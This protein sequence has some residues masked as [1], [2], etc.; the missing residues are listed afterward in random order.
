M[1][2]RSIDLG[3][4]VRNDPKRAKAE[5]LEVLIDNGGNVVW[6]AEDLDINRVT[7]QRWIN[8]LKLNNRLTKIR[9]SHVGRRRRAADHII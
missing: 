9:N 8:R 7:L 5:I 2:N 3:N 1:A 4:A 6:S